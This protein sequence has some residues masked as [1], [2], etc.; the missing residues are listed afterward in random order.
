MNQKIIG[1]IS[2]THGRFDPKIPGL[3]KAVSHVL[4]AGDIGD[5]RVLEQLGRLAPVTAVSGNIDEGN[6]PP[7]LEAEKT[8]LLCGVRIFMIHILGNPQQLSRALQQKIERVQPDVVVFGHSH[9]PLLEKQ[10]SVLYFNPGSAGPKRFALPRSVGLLR[11]QQGEPHGE[12][13]YL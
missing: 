12:L 11:V 4:H 1:V 9:K 5:L 2:D 13:V 6:V 7:G 10:G 3:F 8:V